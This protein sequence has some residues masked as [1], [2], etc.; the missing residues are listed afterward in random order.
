MQIVIY[1]DEEAFKQRDFNA[2]VE[3]HSR[4][5]KRQIDSSKPSFIEAKYRL[6]D[7]EDESG[8]VQYGET[9]EQYFW[10][11]ELGEV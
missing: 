1:S 9:Y 7:L 2:I 10:D 4:F 11:F 3:K 5:F 6:N 8:Y